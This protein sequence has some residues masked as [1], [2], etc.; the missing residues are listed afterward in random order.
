M[1]Q[2]EVGHAVSDFRP[3]RFWRGGHRRHPRFGRPPSSA[4][5]VALWSHWADQ[6]TKIQFVEEAIRRFE[7]KHPGA[8]VKISWYQKPPLEAALKASLPAGIGLDIF[9]CGNG[10]IEYVD[11][12]FLYQLDELVNWNNLEDWTRDAW[13]LGGKTYGLPLEVST[14]ELYYNRDKI[15]QLSATQF[16][17]LVEKAAKAGITPIVQGAGD[18]PTPGTYVLEQTLLEKLGPEDYGKLLKAQLSFKDPRVVDAFQFVKGLVDAG[19]CRKSFSTLKLGESHHYFY[20]NPGG[21]MLP[22]GSWYTSRAFNP[23]DKGGQPADCPLGIMQFPAPDGAAC[24]ECKCLSVAGSYCIDADSKN[25]KL[26]GALLN[27]MATPDMGIRWLTTVLVQTGVKGDSGAVSGQYKAYFDELTALNEGTRYF[28]GAPLTFMQQQC[29]VESVNHD[30][31]LATMILAGWL[32]WERL[33]LRV[34]VVVRRSH[35]AARWGDGCR[36]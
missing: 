2:G 32:S 3:A 19:A 28:I 30:G 26:A 22:M 12:E 29:G 20:S 17:E 35:R 24:P 21:P 16:K 31:R 8:S 27:E 7:K 36:R 10:Q 15:K 9:Y 13:T 1:R 11:D 6:D 23:V 4:Q 33:R 14:V 25:P 5:Q 34:L 18:R